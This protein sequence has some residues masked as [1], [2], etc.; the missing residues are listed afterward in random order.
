MNLKRYKKLSVHTVSQSVL[1]VLLSVVLCVFLNW[2]YYSVQPRGYRATLTFTLSDSVGKSLSIDK[3]NDVVAFLFSLPMI[4]DDFHKKGLHENIH[5]SR[6]GNLINLIF[7]A[8]TMEAAKH[9]LETWFSAFSEAVIKQKQKL[10][11]TKQQANQQYDN[12]AVLNIVQGFRSAVNSF[13][14]YDF[15]QTELN[16]LYM[17][18][19]EATLK[20]IRLTSLNST[21]QMMRKNGQ[22]LLSLSFIAGNSAIAELESKRDLLETQK[23]HMAAQLG[24]SHP[25]IKAMI[26]ESK[27][28]SRQ[29]ENKILQIVH[30]IHSD[31]VIARDFEEQLKK[32]ISLFAKDQYQSLDQIFSELENEITAMVEAQNNEFSKNIPLL[33]DTKI[34]IVMP[35][36]LAPISFMALYGKNIV[37][38]VIASL[39]TLLGGLLL[40][41]KHL[42]KKEC[43]SR[44]NSFKKEENILVSEEIKNLETFVT[45]EGLS[46][47]LKWRASTVVAIIGSEA[48]RTAAKLSL[49]LIKERKT[50][51]LVDVSGQQIEKV[52]GPHRGLSD[53]LTG[54][55]QLQDVIYRD[56]DTGIDILPQGLTSSVRA[57]EFSNDISHI[58]QEFK[59]DYDFVILEMASEPKY[60][61]EQF[62]E[63]TEYYIC[64]VV[65]NEQDWMIKMVS[66]FPKT[67]YRVVTF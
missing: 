32:R 57:Q 20:R 62:A 3:Q 38:S 19:T 12:T 50:I 54:N 18:L 24:W 13:I 42:G 4:S 27:T 25:Q 39:V 16:D 31:E 36:T 64:S 53:I 58:I 49:H 40:F 26:A 61:F 22:S 46:D 67:V 60:G 43:R 66:K 2:L 47:F 34:H 51:L 44:E 6:N 15:K 63:F 33:Q 65:L 21:I 48:A 30:Q 28:L 41:H 35:T 11:F 14:H 17:Q 1:V 45:M 8:E 10:F 23:A 37:V 29:L 7:E 59:K 9:G 55:A 56:Y 5:L 52:I